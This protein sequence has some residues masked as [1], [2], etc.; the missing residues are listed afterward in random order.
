MHKKTRSDFA[1]NDEW[2]SYVCESI[3]VPERSYALAC[4][5]TE[6]FKS[7]YAVRNRA[8][9]SEFSV[10]LER[11]HALAE[12]ERSDALDSL[13]QQILERLGGLL[14]I[15]AQPNATG[16][17]G[18]AEE[19]PA[20]DVRRLLNHLTEKN[21][22]FSLW[23]AYK[24]RAQGDFDA[25]GWEEYLSNE[26]GPESREDIAFT[27]AMVELDRLLQYFL[28]NRLP[29]PEHFY[30]RCWFLHY[31]M[32]SERML[33]TRVLLNTLAAEIKPCASA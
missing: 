24:N 32:G 21:P 27:H 33:H 11:I 22:Y 23:A 16:V 19:N 3:P 1:H 30:D 14:R 5:R 7:F 12:P 31:L 29:L 25:Q 8:F 4:D 18:I 2:L 28:S 10:E 6:L 15:E 17:G 13:N 9:P 26:I 20:N